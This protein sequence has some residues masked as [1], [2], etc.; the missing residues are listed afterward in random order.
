MGKV[1]HGCATTTHAVRTELQRS[2]A[3]IA[4]LARRYNINEKTV[5]KWRARSSVEDVLS[6]MEEAAIVAVN[7]FVFGAKLEFKDYIIL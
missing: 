5:R 1:L 7:C 2:E 4:E 3:P 6:P